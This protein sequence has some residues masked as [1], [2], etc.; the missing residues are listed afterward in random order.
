MAMMYMS[1]TI[2]RRPC[3][4]HLHTN[5]GQTWTS[6]K[7]NPN[8]KLGWSLTRVV[9]VDPAGNVYF[10]WDGYTQN[11]GAKGPGNLYLTKSSNDGQRWSST[12]LDSSSSPP[13]C[14]A[15]N[16][17]W[18]FLG[19]GIAM[20]SDTSGQLYVLWNAGSVDGAPERIYFSASGDE[21]HPWSPRADVLLA[22]FGVDH[23]I[24]SI[25]AEAAGDIRI[26]WMDQRNKPHW[27]EY[28]RSSTDGR[29]SWSGKTVLSSNVAHY[30][31]IFV[32]GFRFPFGD[33]FDM[34]STTRRIGLAWQANQIRLDR[35]QSPVR[36]VP[37]TLN[38]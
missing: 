11:G 21:S 22:P 16:C 2:T 18:A 28:Y 6:V 14:S 10:A 17:G 36:P 20:T 33:Y 1:H 3:G 8:A 31:C 35:P 30:N 12:L 19:P 26:A 25:A 24:P 4:A 13:D 38:Y 23:A 5:G 34:I 32:D 15:F 37:G 27:N 9:T 7:T 29:S